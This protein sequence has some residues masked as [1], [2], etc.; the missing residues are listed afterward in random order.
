MGW[1]QRFSAPEVQKRQVPSVPPIQE[2]PTRAPMGSSSFDSSPS[3]S[4]GSSLRMTEPGVVPEG[5]IATTSPTIWWPG[6][7]VGA[8]GEVGMED[9]G[10]HGSEVNAAAGE[11]A[12]AFD[13]GAAGWKEL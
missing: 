7:I 1:S 2:R 4:S 5:P 12:I 11:M 6:M 8:S 13:L 9:G 10:S 3:A